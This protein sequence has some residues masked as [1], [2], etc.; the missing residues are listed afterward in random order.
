MK[1]KAIIFDLDG[2]LLNTLDDLA[3]SV[4]FILTEHSFPVHNI[5][6]YKTFVGD[7]AFELISRALP[8][9]K[10]ERDFI[11]NLVI[12]FQ[13]IYDKICLAKTR[14]YGNITE[15]LQILHQQNVNLNVL[16]N[17]P[18]QFTVSIVNHY[19]GDISFSQIWGER[20]E[21]ARK[22]NPASAL[23]I[24]KLIDISPSEII[25]VGDSVID[26]KTAI[27]AG[28]MPVG[29]SWG[30]HSAKKLENAGCNVILEKPEDILEFM[31]K[32][33]IL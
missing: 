7:G 9:S 19:F 22:P 26:I 13:E 28:M 29:V 17:K 8:E 15:V 27:S 24:S 16:S 33:R 4:N 21:F 3:D 12:Q 25:F 6:A 14:P 30:Y 1:F 23:E 31:N 32:N 20:I 5:D 18:H 2:T 11:K 10:R